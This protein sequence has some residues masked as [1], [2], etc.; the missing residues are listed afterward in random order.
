MTPDEFEEILDIKPKFDIPPAARRSMEQVGLLSAEEG[1]FA[2]P[3]LSLVRGSLVRVALAKNRGRLVSRW[4]HILLRR[5]LA[6]RMDAPAGMEPV[7]FAALR[8][9]LLLRMGEAEAARALVQD[10]DTGNFSPKLADLA[11]ETYTANADFTGMCPTMATQGS[12]R[13]D[14][15]W[16]AAQSICLAFRGDGDSA[17]QRLDRALG[18]RKMASIDLLLAQKYAGAAGR[19]RRAV[20]IEW[21]EVKSLTP[22]RYG[23]ATAIGMDIPERLLS[24]AGSHYDMVTALAPAA[25]LSRRAAAADTAAGLGILSSAAM[26]DLYSQ[27]YSDQDISGASADH[28]TLLH[29]AYVAADPQ[30]RVDAILELWSDVEGLR[31][32]SRQ[33]LTAYA[34]ARLPVDDSVGD[35]AAGLVASMLSA[36]LDRNAMRWANAVPAGSEAWAQLALAAPKRSAP[37]SADSLDSFVDDD[38]SEEQRKSAFL[39]AGLAGLGRIDAATLDQFSSRLDL[40]LAK[41]SRWSRLIGEAADRNKPALVAL[42]A[43][44]AMQGSDWSAMNPRYLYVIVS[45]LRRTGMEAEARM[46]AAE[47]VARS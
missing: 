43:G 47:A 40:D 33:V 20:T 12:L 31:L 34:A 21:D 22:W 30:D 5:A 46:I 18:G 6:S 16:E 27:I 42:L 38:D 1:G 24:G 28:A 44:L 39:V 15:K 13:E 14:P 3:S 4:G 23:L 11:L 17:M 19:V 37:V 26:V 25:G 45:A 7:D 10:I 41:Q 35:D 2:A 29:N 9:G 36:G 32:Y 8:V